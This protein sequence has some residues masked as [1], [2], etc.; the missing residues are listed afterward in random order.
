MFNKFIRILLYLIIFIALIFFGYNAYQYIMIKSEFNEVD[1]I[2]EQL[3]LKE[4]EDPWAYMADFRKLQEENPDFTGWIKF[5]SGLINQP[6]VSAPD[7]RYLTR[8]FYGDYSDIGT[9]FL[10]S[11]HTVFSRNMTLYGHNVYADTSAMFAPLN[12]LRDSNN[13]EK[14]K[15]FY[16]YLENEVR[17]YVIVSVVEF[18]LNESYD[19]NYDIP[20]YAETEWKEFLNF[21]K[22]HRVYD[23]NEYLPEDFNYVTL[24]TCVPHKKHLRTVVIGKEIEVRLK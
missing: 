9:V 4:K 5:D 2:Q 14:N 17:T 13:Y 6:F 16:L 7:D 10:S 3:E 11:N 12:T 21:A 22:E 23:I 20:E 15:I 24:F 18:N 1:K 19:W 8:N